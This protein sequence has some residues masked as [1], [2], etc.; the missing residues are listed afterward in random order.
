MA[1]VGLIAFGEDAGR[2]EH[3][4][5]EGTGEFAR[6]EQVVQ[7][8]LLVIAGRDVDFAEFEGFRDGEVDLKGGQQGFRRLIVEMEMFD[9]FHIAHAGGIGGELPQFLER[10][11]G[12]GLGERTGD[13]L[14]F[15]ADDDQSVDGDIRV[16]KT[17]LGQ[18]AEGVFA[19]HAEQCG[20]LGVGALDRLARAVGAHAV[21]GVARDPAV[22]EEQG[23]G[24]AGADVD[25]QRGVIAHRRQVLEAAP[26]FQID[27]ARHFP[28]V[29]GADAQAAGDADAVHERLVVS[30][31]AENV[32]G[33]GA[34]DVVRV[35]PEFG[36]GFL[37]AHDDRNHPLGG[38]K[39]DAALAENVAGHRGRLF[40]EINRGERAVGRAFGHHHGNRTRADV[41]GGGERFGGGRRFGGFPD[42]RHRHRTTRDGP[43]FN[44]ECVTGAEL[45]TA[46][47]R[48]RTACRTRGG[49]R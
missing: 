14:D 34:G 28:V 37:I 9:E 46:G 39:A 38:G 12:A 1:G 48:G 23:A 45:T 11:G 2:A 19:D 27:Q 4:L 3:F 25:D 43:G 15:V 17:D 24:V 21:A 32:G 42:F 10:A 26:G 31:L 44:P 35:E 8:S 22:L 16:I 29:D 36:E 33:G 5:G 6:N 49:S 7:Q 47:S 18:V 30:G 40:E 13:G 41:Q 20:A